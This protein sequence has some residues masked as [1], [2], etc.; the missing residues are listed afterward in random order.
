MRRAEGTTFGPSAGAVGVRCG[1]R[2]PLAG[3]GRRG[4]HGVATPEGRS[5]SHRAAGGIPT[6]G[7]PA[8]LH[9]NF[10]FSKLSGVIKENHF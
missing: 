3:S 10:L 1:R 2:G 7:N 9:A 4:G 5:F 6:L 8:W